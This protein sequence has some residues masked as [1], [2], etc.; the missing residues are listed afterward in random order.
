MHFINVEAARDQKTPMWLLAFKTLRNSDM[1]QAGVPGHKR[2]L[3]FA[4]GSQP[5][6]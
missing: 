1:V 3:N 5:G 6:R 2:W 4:K